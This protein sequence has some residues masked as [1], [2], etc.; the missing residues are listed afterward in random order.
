M[1]PIL[2][3][4]IPIIFIILL[5]FHHPINSAITKR[6]KKRFQKK[7]H[8]LMNANIYNVFYENGPGLYYVNL[9]SAAK[10]IPSK[11]ISL[12]SRGWVHSITVLYAENWD[13]YL[14]PIQKDM[15]Q[16]KLNEYYHY[17]ELKN[18]KVLVMGSAD[19]SGMNFFDFSNYQDRKFTIRKTVVREKPV[20]NYICNTAYFPYDVTGLFFWLLRLFDDEKAFYCSEKVYKEWLVGGVKV[21]KHE[22]PSPWDIEKYASARIIYTQ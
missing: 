2:I 9:K 3:S 19:D 5:I 1:I 15:I 21:A 12:F 14:N 13:D 22:K 8:R 18:I 16:G 10:D 20:I 4:I 11:L 6:Y 17:A 7:T